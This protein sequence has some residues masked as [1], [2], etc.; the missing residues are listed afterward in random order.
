MKKSLRGVGNGL[1]GESD[2]T[3]PETWSKS[4]HIMDL[5]L[6]ILQDDTRLVSFLTFEEI[7]KT[8]DAKAFC[9]LCSTSL[10]WRMGK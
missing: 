1:A 10:W 4:F 8:M 2:D 6:F 7:N 3:G 5:V 9:K